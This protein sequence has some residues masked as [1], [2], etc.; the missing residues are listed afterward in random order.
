MFNSKFHNCNRPIKDHLGNIR[1][2]VKA[3]RGTNSVAQTMNYYPFGAEFCDNSTKSFIQKHKYNG[4]ELTRTLGLDWYE[5]G[6]RMYDPT[7]GQWTSADPLAEKYYAWN[8]YVYCFNNPVKFLDP[9]GRK[10]GDFF[11]SINAAAYDFGKYYNDNS[12]RENKEYGSFIFKIKDN[13]GNLGYTYSLASIGK[14]NNV[15]LT[16]EPGAENVATIHTHGAF[17]P[18]LGGGNDSFSGTFDDKYDANPGKLHT[19]EQ[20]MSYQKHDVGNA[21]K[22]GLPSFLVTPNGTLS[23]YNPSTGKVG[24]LSNDMPSDIYDPDRMSNI[25]V[26]ETERSNWLDVKKMQNNINEGILLNIII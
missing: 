4:K 15:I 6:A 12:I 18:E 7:R 25:G 2:V 19:P 23:M 21:N 1:Q 13:D 16:S 8:V 17:D 10:P 14:N 22:R 20:N 3:Y 9:D 5:Y 11:K 26:V 24:I